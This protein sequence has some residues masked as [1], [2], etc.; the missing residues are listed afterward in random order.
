MSKLQLILYIFGSSRRT[1]NSIS[2]LR[3]MLDRCAGIPYELTVCDVLEEPE[4]A[5]TAKVLATPTLMTVAPPPVRRFVGDI[6]EPLKGL[7][8]LDLTWQE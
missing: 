6:S 3:Q 8:C 5:E 2:R 7:P 1:G 4:A